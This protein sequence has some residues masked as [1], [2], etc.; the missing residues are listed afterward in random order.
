M[1]EIRE[2]SLEVSSE[3]VKGNVWRGESV[4]GASKVRGRELIGQ[5]VRQKG[6]M[7]E[8]L[9]KCS[10]ERLPRSGDTRD[11]SRWFR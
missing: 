5:R 11:G 8:E 6:E 3:V 10:K 9:Q 4:R 1:A 2:R 7:K